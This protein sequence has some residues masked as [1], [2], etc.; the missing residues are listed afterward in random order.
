MI[1]G[2][3]SVKKGDVGLSSL[4][5]L[6]SNLNV[7]HC[8]YT[9]SIDYPMRADYHLCVLCCVNI[10]TAYLYQLPAVFCQI[11]IFCERWM[12]GFGKR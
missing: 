3:L 11:V 7:L 12:P 6:N 9:V 10:V 2:E 4:C 8:H 5:I 1:M